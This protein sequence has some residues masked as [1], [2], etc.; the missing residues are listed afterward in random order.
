V[1][2]MNLNVGGVLGGLICGGL[3]GAFL[4]FAGD[5][6]TRLRNPARAVVLAVIVG[7]AGGNALWRWLFPEE[8]KSEEKSEA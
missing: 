8:R 2:N 6:N 1:K 4:F 5:A 7:G 3:A